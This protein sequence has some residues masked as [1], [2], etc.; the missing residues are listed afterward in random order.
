MSQHEMGLGLG[1]GSLVQGGL[2]TLD[3]IVNQRFEI[4]DV[5]QSTTTMSA[6][7]NSLW[8]SDPSC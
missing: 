3:M 1:E 2:G 4:L 7:V 8:Q 6:L 5:H